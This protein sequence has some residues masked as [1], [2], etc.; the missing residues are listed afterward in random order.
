MTGAGEEPGDVPGG[1]ADGQVPPDPDRGWSRGI[2]T[3]GDALVVPPDIHGPR[4]RAGILA[5]GGGFCHHGANWRFDRR[6]SYRPSRRQGSVEALAGRWLWG[7]QI[8]SH[9][10]HFLTESTS[11]LW[12]LEGGAVDG[13]LFIPKQPGDGAVLRGFQRQFFD[14][15]GLT[16]P[17]RV[18]AA[19]VR[20]ETLV[21]PGQ[22]FG[23]GTI[24]RGTPEMRAL[25]RGRFARQVA[26][27]GPER[28]YLSR[29]G[30][31]EAGGMVLC[32]RRLEALLEAEGY[33]VF[34]PQDH[35]LATQVARYRAA[36][37]IVIADGSAAHLYAM[38]GR[39]DQ[40][41]A[42]LPRRRT[43]WEFQVAHITHFCGR[44][45][46]V[47]DALAREWLP[48]RPRRHRHMSFAEF[49][50]PRLGRMLREAGFVAGGD[51]PALGSDE[52][53]AAFGRM[54]LAGA[55]APDER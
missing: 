9:F 14:L 43:W 3:L 32:E 27:E 52:V 22:G 18:A 2:V 13:V 49:D 33:V 48:L 31:G 10:G 40:Q 21:V 23:L 4:Q 54:G 17:V 20:V 46:L 16:Q 25:M 8:A 38:V 51:W 5:A 42:F 12:A 24:S 26:P 36:R 19:A 11:R 15:L 50:L 39:A 6:M 35:D 34:H 41:V 45:P 55:F 28:L 53:V 29:S 30:L 37:Q 44:A 1:R 7:G 47:A